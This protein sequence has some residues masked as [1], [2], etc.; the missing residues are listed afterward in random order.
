[1]SGYVSVWDS[2]DGLDSPV[3][4]LRYPQ[5]GSA[6]LCVD[7]DRAQTHFVF[8]G[9]DNGEV[10]C[11]DRRKENFPVSRTAPHEGQVWD[12]R[13]MNVRPGVLLSCGEDASVLA[14][15]FASAAYRGVGID[16]YWTA[17]VTAGEIHQLAV[18][19]TLGVNSVDVHPRGDL[20]AYVSDSST[21]TLTSFSSPN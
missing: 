18:G 16:E 1:M 5:S 8:A 11:W 3:Q 6:L 7:V 2:R 9:T 10:V 4:R 13:V 20:V 12:V 14:W 21:I 15:D 17:E 19:R